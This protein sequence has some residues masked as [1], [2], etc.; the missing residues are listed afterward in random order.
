MSK[1]KNGGLDQYGSEAFEQ[2]QFGTAGIE[3]V[4][5]NVITLFTKEHDDKIHD[6]NTN[7]NSFT[8]SDE[9]QNV[10]EPFQHRSG[11][12]TTGVGTAVPTA[13]EY[14]EDG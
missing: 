7:T 9:L 8:E 5:L 4:V 1:I 12:G 2:Q 13:D 10:D 14:A 11:G 3:G 6:R